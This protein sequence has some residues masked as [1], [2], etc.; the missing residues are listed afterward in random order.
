[1]TQLRRGRHYP[2]LPPLLK[3]ETLEMYTD[4]LTGA[5]Q[6][7]RQPYDH[8]RFRACCL[9]WHAE[10][11]DPAGSRCQCPCHETRKTTKRRRTNRG[12]K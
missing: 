9:G 12:G 6:M 1:M 2:K 7:D 3:G 8:I 4:R 10:C 5:D 11:S